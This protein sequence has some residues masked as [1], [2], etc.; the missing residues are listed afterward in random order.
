MSSSDKLS[1]LESIVYHSSGRTKNVVDDIPER[2]PRRNYNPMTGH[3]RGPLGIDVSRSE[4][5]HRFQSIDILRRRFKTAF[6]FPLGIIL[7][8]HRR[9]KSRNRA[10]EISNASKTNSKV[11]TSFHRRCDKFS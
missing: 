5:Y 10:E 7:L 8:P 4:R 3:L 2:G 11:A 9:Y 6:R 1:W